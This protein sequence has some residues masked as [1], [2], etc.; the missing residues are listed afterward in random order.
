M[1]MMVS[2]SLGSLRAGLGMNIGK[3]RLAY[4]LGMLIT[5][6]LGLDIHVKMAS[7]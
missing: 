1:T 2:K 4:V 6:R 7:L 5:S 3:Y